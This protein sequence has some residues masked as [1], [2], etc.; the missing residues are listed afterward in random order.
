MFRRTAATA[1]LFGAVVV[2]TAI[3]ATVVVWPQLFGV[4]RL[5]IVAQL[6]SLRGLA[7]AGALVVIVVL[8]LCAV[9]FRRVRL[10]FTS[11]GVVVAVFVIASAVVLATRGL[12]DTSFHKKGPDDLT[13]LSWN[14][15]GGAPGAQEIARVALATDADIVSLP[16]TTSDIAIEV[17][18]L[19]K[20]GGHPMWA[21]TFHYDL[22]SKSRSTSLLT[23]VAL[24][25]Y[26]VDGHFRELEPGMVFTIE[27][28]LY[29]APGSKGVAAKWQGI[30]VRIEDDV[31]ITKNGH[32]VLTDGVPREIDEVE[33]V[34]AGR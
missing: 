15:L 8:T 1:I 30:G 14:T 2:G 3:A 7:I 16:E 29:I 27:P 6:V 32:E 24:G 4:Q 34:L 23:S 18:K 11:L 5:P 26:R 22:I 10:L 33:A 31:L 17:A 21:H 28:G 12:G 25:E 19:M 9:F 13:V 20:A